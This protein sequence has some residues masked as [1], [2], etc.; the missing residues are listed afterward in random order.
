MKPSLNERIEN[1]NFKKAFLG[2]FVAFFIFATISTIISLAN[3]SWEA[4]ADESRGSRRGRGRSNQEQV[5]MLDES[6]LA[7]SE[8]RTRGTI[9]DRIVTTFAGFGDRITSIN[10][11]V[12]MPLLFIAAFNIL[13]ALWVYVDSSKHGNNKILWSLVTLFTSIIGLVVYMI[14]RENKKVK[15]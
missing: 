12:A 4:I 13:I 15:K 3:G 1:I 9:G 8:T 11:G 14:A 6:Y 2:F 5:V 10:I 7:Y